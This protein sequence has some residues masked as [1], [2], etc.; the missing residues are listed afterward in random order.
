MTDQT[1]V[2]N[3]IR[4]LQKHLETA[5]GYEKLLKA[6]LT[7]LNVAPSVDDLRADITTLELEKE[8]L[9]DHLEGLRSGRIK[10]IPPA[11][12]EAVDKDWG[13][14]K[15]KAESRKRIFMEMWA[16]VQDGLPEGQT[17]E[18][19]WV[20]TRVYFREDSRSLMGLSRTS[21]GW[22]KTRNRSEHEILVIQ[23]LI[24]RSRSTWSSNTRWPSLACLIIDFTK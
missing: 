10:P 3:Q 21:L 16:V 1:A 23:P 7:A 24:L 5:K 11:E 6:R 4:Q 9:V 8:E 17:K 14:W 18:Q 2:G 19:L 12:K 13:F 22:R 20:R 15:R